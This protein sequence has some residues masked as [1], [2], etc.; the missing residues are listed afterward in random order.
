M[1]AA[2]SV[3]QVLSTEVQIPGLDRRTRVDI[4]GV[5]SISLALGAYMLVECRCNSKVG[6]VFPSPTLPKQLTGE[7]TCT[8][9]LAVK[10]SSLSFA[11]FRA[12]KIGVWGAQ[13]RGVVWNAELL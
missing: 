5:W 12:V 10:S 13:G 1:Q 2:T 8:P 9:H 7:Q 4:P 3:G 6:K 11:R